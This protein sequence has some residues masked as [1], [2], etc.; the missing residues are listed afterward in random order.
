MNLYGQFSIS[1]CWMNKI[2][3]HASSLEDNRPSVH[4]SVIYK[5]ETDSERLDHSPRYMLSSP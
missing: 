3:K 2:I 5:Q 4:L 1:I